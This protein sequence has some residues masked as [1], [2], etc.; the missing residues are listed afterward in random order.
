M[1]DLNRNALVSVFL[2]L[3][4][5][6]DG[7]LILTSNRVGTFDEAFKSRIQLA[8]HYENLTAS[9]RRNI[10]RNFVN[11]LKTLEE[12][13]VDFDDILDHLDDLSHEDMNG[14]DI[15]NVITTAR[16]VAQFKDRPVRYSHLRGVIKV[17]RKFGKYMND[18]RYGLTDDDI[19]REGGLRL[20]YKASKGKDCDHD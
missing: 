17:S 14:R 6:Y 1:K 15:R 19:K 11:R 8:L 5:Y 20:S 13:N 10:W 18:L 4:E 7:I 16:Q 2:R 9:Q 3:L 12:P